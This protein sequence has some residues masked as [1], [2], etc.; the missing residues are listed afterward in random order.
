MTTYYFILISGIITVGKQSSFTGHGILL[1]ELPV[2][3]LYNYCSPIQVGE[4]C[5]VY[6]SSSI[7]IAK[8][9]C[10]EVWNLYRDVKPLTHSDILA[11]KALL[12][13]LGS[14]EQRGKNDQEQGA[15]E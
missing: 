6:S 4:P 13:V 9:A 5:Q 14:R 1:D 15:W 2:V 11:L 12:G 8:F 3:L 7:G 10:R